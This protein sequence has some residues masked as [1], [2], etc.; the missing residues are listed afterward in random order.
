M[1]ASAATSTLEQSAIPP[2][3]KVCFVLCVI[4]LSYFPTAYFADLWI[5][6]AD[7]RGTPT[8]FVNVW[9]AGRLVLEGPRR[10]P[11]TGISR[12]RSSSRC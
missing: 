4:N 1:V 8:D 3:V 5:Y 2:V 7:G 12:S 11:T 9:A 10:W 6:Q